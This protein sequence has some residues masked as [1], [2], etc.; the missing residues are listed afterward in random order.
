MAQI[1][2]FVGHSFDDRDKD[3]VNAFTD[4]FDS[5]KIG[6]PFDWDHAKRV[7]AK[8]ISDKVKEKMENKDL[9]IGIFTKKDYRISGDKIKEEDGGKVYISKGDLICGISDW[10]VQESGYALGKGMS[11][12][13][14]VEEGINSPSGLQGDLECIEFKRDNLSLSFQSIVEAIGNLINKIQEGATVEG[15]IFTSSGIKAEGEDQ[16]DIGFKGKESAMGDSESKK[17]VDNYLSLRKFIVEENDLSKAINE[18]NKILDKF[19][20]NNEFDETFWRIQFLNFKIE[21]GYSEGF[22]ELQELADK[23]PTDMRPRLSLA[24]GYKKYKTY[25]EA[26]KQYQLLAVKEKD[27]NKRVDSLIEAAECYSKDKNYI[28]AKNIVLKEFNNR[29]YNN[30]QLSKLYKELALLSKEEGNNNH[31]ISFTEKALVNSPADENLRFKLA[32]HLNEIGMLSLSYYHY[33]ILCAENPSGG[34]FNNIGLLYDHL[35]MPGKAVNSFQKVIKNYYETLAVSN[36]ANKYINEGF[37]DDAKEILLKAKEQEDYHKNV[38]SSLLDIKRKIDNEN[39]LEESKSE[40][41]IKER[42]FMIN[43]AEAYTTPME[44]NPEGEWDF[45]HGKI[46]L[47]R[48][49]AIVTGHFEVAPTPP[50]APSS[51]LGS[52]NVLLRLGFEGKIIDLEGKINN[53]AVEY[54]LEIKKTSPTDTLLTTSTTEYEGLMYIDDDSKIIKVM[55]RKKDETEWEFYEM[56][57]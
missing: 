27:N 40:S 38:D 7:E 14:L 8:A 52:R 5:L 36:L 2:A 55:E 22:E 48:E 3:V 21:A 50:Q 42:K 17:F 19:K 26:A 43:Y 49:G 11:L 28:E 24:V 12:L 15:P 44:I 4:Y 57:K 45:E 51:G 32:H 53:R 54:S 56:K 20:G 29:N 9:F 34:S 41:V 6:M 31:F 39:E 13:F 47:N 37:Y 35:Q 18:L 30:F 10:I 25:T 46:N 23:N 1:R 33:K 16:K